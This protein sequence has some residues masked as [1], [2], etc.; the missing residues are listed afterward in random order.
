MLN[1]VI[2]RAVRPTRD[3]V[4]KFRGAVAVL[5]GAVV[6]VFAF[7][8]YL[9]TLA[10]TVLYYARPIFFDSAMLQAEAS[11]LGIG[12]PSGYPTYMMLTH[13]FTYLP[14]GDEAHL[15]NLASA[16]YGAVSVALFYAI[17]LR[18]SGRIVA[19][20]A[21]ALAFAVSATFWSQAVITE[22]Y[23]LNTVFIGLIFL[24]LLVWRET[25]KDRYLLLAAFVM[26][27]SL[28]HHLTSGILLPGGFA[29]I[30]LTERRKLFEAGLMLKGLGL[31]LL[32][33]TPYIYLP[34][35]ALMNAPLTEADPSTLG[36][37]LLL[38]TGSSLWVP[39]LQDRS[40]CAPSPFLFVDFSERLRL[41]GGHLL[42]QFPVVLMLVGALGVIYLLFTDR[43]LA[44]LL[45]TVSFGVLAQSLAY[46]KGGTEDY[47]VF[48][49]PAYL[50]FG[51]CVSIG[52]GILLRRMEGLNLRS[53]FFKQVLLILFSVLMLVAPFIGIQKTYE[54]N[55]QSHNYEGR[56]IV[57]AVVRETKPNATVLHHRSPLW[58]MVLAEKKRRDLTLMDPFCTSWVR[59]RDIVW[60]GS[61]SYQQ[62]AARYKIGDTTG[63]AA[64]REAAKKGPVYILAQEFKEKKTSPRLFEKAGFDVVPVEKG[65]LYRLV[66]RKGR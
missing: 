43:A 30:F 17:S 64:A 13:L 29:F 2:F 60:P 52:L 16:V 48:L 49:I 58:Y 66:P 8:L 26:G 61:L 40:N 39:S 62:A 15:T 57:D 31:F 36:R 34:I 59:Y 27:L 19:A 10:P 7:V 41:Y 3:K 35:R 45:G 23:T 4:D 55:Y 42:G 37:F 11:V 5:A 33:L 44:A 53:S 12:H 54:A 24:I 28:T 20:A 9:M 21:G 46:L 25:R 65:I 32:G 56:R 6:V 63:V 50:S 18:L 1:V 47:F 38:V 22:V 51:L 14:F